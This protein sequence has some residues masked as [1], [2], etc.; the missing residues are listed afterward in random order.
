MPN[1]RQGTFEITSEQL[2]VEIGIC[3]EPGQYA[4]PRFDWTGF[5]HQVK[6]NKGGHTFCVPESFIPGEGTGGAG[7]C[8]EFISD[9]PV[10]YDEAK[11]GGQFPKIGIGKL[12]RLDERGY[13]NGTA[14]PV[15]PCP[16]KIESGEDFARFIAEPVICNGYAFAYEKTLSVQGTELKIE[17]K[18]SNIGD[19]PI[20]TLEYVH[21]FV[22]IDGNSIG[23]GCQLRLPLE[24]ANR[25]GY[26]PS[27]ILTKDIRTAG[28]RIEW[29]A[30]TGTFYAQYRAADGT[31]PFYWELTDE[32]SGAGMREKGSEP[33]WHY[34]LWG[35]SHVVSLEAF[36][37]VDVLPGGT[38]SWSRTYEFFELER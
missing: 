12:T 35:Q 10:G 5:V 31:V 18:L 21:N 25:P 4:G 14:Y 23:P 24:I 6:L 19:K 28:D 16:I 32:R 36:V 26:E 7:L 33:V 38:K 22:A 11:P 17:Y 2:T 13:I 8:N 34:S 27:P 29:D 1:K 3:G 20:H 37:R 9:L 15:E 30:V